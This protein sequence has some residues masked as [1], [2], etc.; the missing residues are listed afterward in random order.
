MN[1]AA[2]VFSRF[3]TRPIGCTLCTEIGPVMSRVRFARSV[4]A[5]AR[6]K[7]SHCGK[8]PRGPPQVKSSLTVASLLLLYTPPPAAAAAAAAALPGTDLISR[9]TL[10]ES[11]THK[12]SPKIV[13]S[14]K[15]VNPVS[16]IDSFHLQRKS[17]ACLLLYM[18]T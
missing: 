9:Y 11:S 2:S 17:A 6:K 15:N 4:G 16:Q 18:N 3:G 1:A 14:S 13:K 5:W 12:K 7:T 8:S 10:E